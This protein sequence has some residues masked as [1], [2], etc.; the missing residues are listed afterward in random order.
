MSRPNATSLTLF[1][2]QLRRP[3]RRSQD[4]LAK[5]FED[6]IYPLYGQ[7]F[8]EMMLRAW[9][10]AP[11]TAV[12]ELGC[13]AGAVTAELL[14]RLDGESRIVAL[15]SSPA[16]LDR[17]RRAVGNEHAGRRVFFRQHDAWARRPF[18]LP[19]AD[20][21]QDTVLAH[22][23]LAAAPDLPGAV[24]ELVRITKPGGQ[25]VV[26]LP[27]RGTWGELLDLLREV[28]V[29]LGRT[30][31]ATALD[32]HVAAQPEGETVA[33]ALEEADL[34]GVEEELGRWELLFRSGREF[35]YAPVIEHGPLPRWKE[36]AGQ[37]DAMHEVFFALKEAIDT[38]YAGHTFAV[39]VFGGCFSARKPG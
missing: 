1:S 21:T 23:V 36:I 28:L 24:R 6:E 8:A 3:P 22:P 15:E 26:C 19:F 11:R 20:E 38:Y 14:H 13:G 31:A 32:T 5:V 39:G 17:A 10:P 9:R 35:F 18:K 27:L 34:E 2:P 4:R 7:R 29:A 12:L 30:E 16:L 25:V 33:R 37:G